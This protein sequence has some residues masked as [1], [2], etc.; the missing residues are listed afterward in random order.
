M[1]RALWLLAG[2]L[3]TACGGSGLTFPTAPVPTPIIAPPTA[4]VIP[5]TAA[6]VLATAP[7]LVATPALPSA[8]ASVAQPTTPAAT[9]TPMATTQQ[10]GQAGGLPPI[11]TLPP[12]TLVPP[13]VT[14]ASAG[15]G[16]V[17][18][19]GTTCP[20]AYPIKGNDTTKIYHVPGQRDYAATNARNCFATEQA[21]QAAGYRRSQV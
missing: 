3:C 8:V 19:T 5:P 7:R 13:A 15:T 17:A 21:A 9:V 6:R 18:G 20:T 14:T 11:V 12:G 16:P 2:L 1:R 10:S 4:I